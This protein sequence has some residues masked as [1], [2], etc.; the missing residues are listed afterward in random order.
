[1]LYDINHINKAIIRV[2]GELSYER[3][4]DS[5]KELEGII[6][7]FFFVAADWR[8]DKPTRDFPQGYCYPRRADLASLKKMCGAIKECIQM[9]SSD[10]YCQIL[11]VR[12]IVEISEELMAKFRQQRDAGE[13]RRNPA[14]ICELDEAS[15]WGRVMLALKATFI[16]SKKVST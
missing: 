7:H 9:S 16:E 6:G 15:D 4:P 2:L 3:A 10:G 1:M 5:A 12:R 14:Y 8:D 13:Y 11:L